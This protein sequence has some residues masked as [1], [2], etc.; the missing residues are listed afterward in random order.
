VAEPLLQVTD[1]GKR[2]DSRSGTVTAIE[3]LS[4]SVDD[5]ELVG[6]VGPSGGGKTTMVRVIAGLLRPTTGTVLLAGRRVESPPPDLIVLFQQYE[7]TLLPWRTVEGNVRFGLENQPLDR[8][9]RKRRVAEALEAVGLTEAARQ[10]P[11]QLSGGMQQRAAIARALARR[12]RI[13]LMDEPF[14]SLDAL[15][16]ADLQDL[17][18]RLWQEHGQ[19][20]LFVTHDVDEA[21]YL[22]TRVLVLSARPARV[23]DDVRVQL[24]YPRNQIQ[25]R[26][27][28]RYLE[29][30]HHVYELIRSR[31]P[32]DAR[33]DT[34]LSV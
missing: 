33:Q 14:S 3:G 29:V 8:Q 32:S 11:H 26:E 20:I 22:A 2:F 17:L 25:T 23:R 5:G 6:V 12:P 13:L 19:T 24:P 7:K 21:V 30:R 27:D 34:A 31:I 28:P 15:T 10:Y 18:L 9:E 4:F 16:R 1:L